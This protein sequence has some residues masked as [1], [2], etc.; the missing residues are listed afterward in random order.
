MLKARRR[1][2]NMTGAP[3]RRCRA[4][5]PASAAGDHRCRT[6]QMDVLDQQRRA[7]VKSHQRPRNRPSARHWSQ[8]DSAL[9]TLQND[10]ALFARRPAHGAAGARRP[11]QDRCACQAKPSFSPALLADVIEHSARMDREISDGYERQASSPTPPT[12]W[13]RPG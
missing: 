4:P 8:F 7:I 12:C 13:S 5:T 9:T 6:R 2:A 10:A 3:A 11:G 1:P